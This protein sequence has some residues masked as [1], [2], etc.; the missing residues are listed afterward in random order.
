MGSKGCREVK[1]EGPGEHMSVWDTRES[2]QKQREE[3]ERVGN[4]KIKVEWRGESESVCGRE[5]KREKGRW[6]GGRGEK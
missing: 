6:G 3:G 1:S 5:R 4:K 2:K